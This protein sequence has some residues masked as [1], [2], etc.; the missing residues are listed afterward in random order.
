MINEMTNRTP[1]E[2]R[3]LVVDY[4]KDGARFVLFLNGSK[5]SSFLHDY[6]NDTAYDTVIEALSTIKYSCDPSW[7][8]YEIWMLPEDPNRRGLPIMSGECDDIRH[9]DIKRE[10]DSCLMRSIGA[11]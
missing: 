10:R 3:P 8:N 2:W 11:I 4:R 5:G 1:H 7:K 9:T 6:Y